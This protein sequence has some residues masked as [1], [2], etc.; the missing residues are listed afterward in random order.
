MEQQLYR[1]FNESVKLDAIA[2]DWLNKDKRFAEVYQRLP[3]IRILRQQ[4]WECTISFICS[5]NNNISR[6]TKMLNGLRSQYGKFIKKA[7]NT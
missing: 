7:H 1:Y 3:G 5:S 6:I 2:S 4:P